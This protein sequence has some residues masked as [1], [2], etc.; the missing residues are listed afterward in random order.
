MKPPSYALDLMHAT[1]YL[2]GA[3]KI[4]KGSTVEHY[5]SLPIYVILREYSLRPDE[6]EIMAQIL[7]NRGHYPIYKDVAKK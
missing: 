6:Q 4:K 2:F 7:R 5:F 1:N 3:K